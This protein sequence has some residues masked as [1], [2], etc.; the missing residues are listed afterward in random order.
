MNLIDHKREILAHILSGNLEAL[1]A[2]QAQTAVKDL[3]IQLV[4]DSREIGGS[5][6]VVDASG[7]K[8]ELSAQEFDA[9]PPQV[10]TRCVVIIDT[11]DGQRVP[12]PDEDYSNPDQ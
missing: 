1:R 8:R 4:M 11:T 3:N 10:R 9:L 7:T 12:G 2:Y 5:I 6:E